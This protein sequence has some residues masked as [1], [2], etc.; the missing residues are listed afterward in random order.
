M[1]FDLVVEHMTY[2]IPS[3]RCW[4]EGAWEFAH[5]VHMSLVDLENAYDLVPRVIL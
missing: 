4:R 2:S 1:F 5:S 3:Q